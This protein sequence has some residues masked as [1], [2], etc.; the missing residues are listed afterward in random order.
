MATWCHQPVLGIPWRSCRI[1]HTVT[2]LI[3]VFT[4]PSI[5]LCPEVPLLLWAFRYSCWNATCCLFPSASSKAHAARARCNSSSSLAVIAAEKNLNTQ[6]DNVLAQRE[7]SKAKARRLQVLRKEANAPYKK[8]S[9]TPEVRGGIR[10]EIETSGH[11]TVLSVESPD[12]FMQPWK[13]WQP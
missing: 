8:T 3:F 6:I 12:S 9:L 11:T 13:T 10:L 2:H 7:K 1:W 5:F 4:Q